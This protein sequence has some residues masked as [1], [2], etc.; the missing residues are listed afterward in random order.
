MRPGASQMALRTGAALPLAIDIVAA[1]T[2]AAAIRRLVP[3][4]AGTVS[5]PTRLITATVILPIRPTVG[6]GAVL[7]LQSR[8]EQRPS[9]PASL[10]ETVHKPLRPSSAGPIRPLLSPATPLRARLSVG[11]RVAVAVPVASLRAIPSAWPA[12]RRPSFA[13]RR[14][15]ADVTPAANEAVPVF[16]LA[17]GAGTLVPSLRQL[18]SALVAEFAAGPSPAIQV[19]KAVAFRPGALAPRGK[20]LVLACPCVLVESLLESARPCSLASAAPGPLR[21][22]AVPAARP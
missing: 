13:V 5:P 16:L 10:L 15:P 19:P 11:L 2:P 8:P 12:V 9:Y 1:A 20:G 3:S 6:P 18:R 22:V 21:P 14:M 4:P 7:T 17:A